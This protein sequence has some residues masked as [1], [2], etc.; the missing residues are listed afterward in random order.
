MVVNIQHMYKEELI[1]E[2]CLTISPEPLVTALIC[3]YNYGRYLAEAI[4][5]VLAQTWQNIEILVV[6]DGSTDE[7]REVLKRYE[8]RIRIILKENGGQASAFNIGVSQACGEIICFLDSDDYWFSDKVRRVVDKFKEEKWCLIYHDL[9]EVDQN[10]SDIGRNGYVKSSGMVWEEGFMGG[11]ITNE[12]FTPAFSPTSGIS[13]LASIAREIVPMP[14][15]DWCLCAD[16]PLA[17][18]AMLHGSVGIIDACLAGYRYHDS[19]GFLSGRKDP[20]QWKVSNFINITKRY[21]YLKEY[22]DKKG[23]PF[24]VR[25]IK[26]NYNFYRSWVLIVSDKPIRYLFRLWKS[27]WM[28]HNKLSNSRISKWP[29]FAFRSSRDAVLVFL[30]ALNLSGRYTMVRTRFQKEYLKLTPQIQAF[31][32]S[33]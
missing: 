20:S 8:G 26:S 29:G 4:D 2:G 9:L 21:F 3:N 10:N 18:A 30:I 33:N 13:L 6:D 31:L 25:N 28:Y 32:S 5:S 15:D 17:Y 24:R 11:K 16:A 23:L 19:N 27:S 7:S 1:P 14:E 12:G 22:V